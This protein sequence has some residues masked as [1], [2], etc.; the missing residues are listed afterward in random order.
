MQCNDETDVSGDVC[1]SLVV[2]SAGLFPRVCFSVMT[3]NYA[4]C[5]AHWC[6]RGGIKHTHTHTHTHSLTHTHTNRKD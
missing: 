3:G 1:A 6:R 4:I 5:P 2:S